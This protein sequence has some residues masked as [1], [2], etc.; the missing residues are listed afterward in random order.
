[1]RSIE[2]K[3]LALRQELSN[4]TFTYF[5]SQ[6][7]N[8]ARIGELEQSIREVQAHLDWIQ[9]MDRKFGVGGWTI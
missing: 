4:H 3:I 5:P 8:R 9:T 2:E 1:M 7:R 6:P